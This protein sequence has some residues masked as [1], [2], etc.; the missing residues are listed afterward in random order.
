MPQRS[1]WYQQG[2]Q[3]LFASEYLEAIDCFLALARTDS[4]QAADAFER[5]T[6]SNSTIRVV[7]EAWR[8]VPSKP[9]LRVISRMLMF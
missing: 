3:L 2:Q 4:Q 7:G 6:N 5:M 8:A 9:P 1:E